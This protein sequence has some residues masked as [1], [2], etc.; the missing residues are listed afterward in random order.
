MA[1]MA[2]AAAA[3][4]AVRATVHNGFLKKLL[5][6]FTSRGKAQAGP[7]VAG[8]LRGMALGFAAAALLALAEKRL[9]LL[10]PGIVLLLGGGVMLILQ[11]AK[12]EKQRD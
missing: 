2:G 7:G 12:A 5:S 1:F 11:A 4:L 9:A 8:F 6:S 10:I 3:Y